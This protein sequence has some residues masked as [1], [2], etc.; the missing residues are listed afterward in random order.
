[1]DLEN[2]NKSHDDLTNPHRSQ[3][4]KISED[5]NVSIESSE[6]VAK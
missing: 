2:Q 6:G 4:I 5:D 3:A 1:V